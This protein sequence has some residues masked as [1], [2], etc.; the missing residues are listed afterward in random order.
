MESGNLGAGWWTLGQVVDGCWEVPTK[1][2]HRHPWK[3]VFWGRW[4]YDEDVRY[5]TCHTPP[6]QPVQEVIN[7]IPPCRKHACVGRVLAAAVHCIDYGK[8]R[9]AARV[10]TC[11]HA[12]AQRTLGAWLPSKP[13]NSDGPENGTGHLQ[14]LATQQGYLVQHMNAIYRQGIRAIG[15]PPDGQRDSQVPGRWAV[16][17]RE[18]STN[19]ACAEGVGTILGLDFIYLKQYTHS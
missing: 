9:F 2:L 16:R 11:L 1:L 19:L 8:T 14:M 12:G 3:C 15:R 6:Q 4:E 10:P 5:Q 13:H 18:A 7:V 17:R